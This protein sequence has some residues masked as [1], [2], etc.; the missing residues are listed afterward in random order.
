MKKLTTGFW[1]GMI[2]LAALLLAYWGGLG[3]VVTRWDRQEEY[4]HGYF[5]PVLTAWMLWRRKDALQ[6]SM[7][8]GAWQ[9]LAVVGIGVFALLLGELTALFILIQYGFLISL[10]G[11]VLCLGGSGIFRLSVVPIVFLAFAIPLPYFIEAKLTAGMQLLSSQIGVAVLRVLGSAVFLEGNVIDLGEYKLQVVEACSGLRY[12]YPLL[13]IGFL[14]GF[15]YRAPFW[16]RS[17]VFLTTVP[18]TIFMNSLRIAMVGLLVERWGSD[19]ADGFLHY[20]EGWIVFM[21]CLGMLLGEIWL[22][23]RIG[24]GRKVFDCLDLPE[25]SPVKPKFLPRSFNAPLAGAILLLILAIAGQQLMNSRQELQPVRSSL[26][27]FP[28]K[29]GQWQAKE[30]GLSQQ[31]ESALG[32]DDYI[33]ADYRRTDEPTVNFYVAYYGSQRKGVSPHSP[34]VC[35][36]GG[37]WAITSL[38]PV[39]MVVKG[40]LPFNA[41]RV[42]IERDN[43]RQLVYYW[44]EGRGRR[45]ANEYLV[46]WNL[47]VDALFKNRTDGALVRITTPLLQEESTEQA[48][49]RLKAF[50]EDAVPALSA[51]VPK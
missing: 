7:G 48:D 33:L 17:V 4:G 29:L 2:A 14:M 3:E 42:V 36:P 11:L 47:F 23:E 40:E 44:F 19:M 49:I 25:V 30:S 12:L 16:Q 32:L 1:M 41:Y 24:S 39:R 38:E 8:S 10:A 20:F 26:A 46:K 15:M 22:F 13:S 27:T 34:A 35:M 31:V 28:L 43:R 45:V 51:Y 21:L 6:A 18:I 50:M 37:G 9:G 5:I